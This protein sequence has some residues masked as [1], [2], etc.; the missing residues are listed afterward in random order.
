MNFRI[1]KKKVMKAANPALTGK[2]TNAQIGSFI[3]LCNAN[4]PIAQMQLTRILP[5]RT[6]RNGLLLFTLRQ[7]YIQH[8]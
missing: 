6:I 7:M 8:L 2:I 3:V 5:I 1:R 4:I